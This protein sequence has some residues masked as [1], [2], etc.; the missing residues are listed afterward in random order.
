MTVKLQSSG[1]TLVE[2][3]VATT[4]TV[5]VGGSTVAILRSTS[6]A[7]RRADSQLEL[8]QQAR[9]AVLTVATALRNA[10]RVPDNQI[11]L[12]GLDDWLDDNHE[13]PSDSIR[14]VTVSRR[15]VRFGQPE[16]DVKEC[17]FRL[18]PPSDRAL[19]ALMCRTDPTRNDA[20]DGGGVVEL[21][22]ENVLGFNLV[23]HDGT[24]WRS[25]WPST[26]QSWPLAVRIQLA[27]V[28]KTDPSKVWT[29]S[30]VV[31]F[32][33]RAAQEEESQTQ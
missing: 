20:P 26:L 2:L 1:F 21:V 10:H 30:R 3:I 33:Y 11:V 28:G 9:S 24:G 12:E 19:P 13:I 5:L 32:P 25:D 6:A 22:A 18:S 14:F 4:L 17:E 8:Q 16:S 7:C 29:T 27:V 31:N 15:T 23:Y